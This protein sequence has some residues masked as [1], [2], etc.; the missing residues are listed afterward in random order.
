MQQTIKMQLLL[1]YSIHKC[2]YED[3]SRC[4]HKLGCHLYFR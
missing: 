4:H 3:W 2:E 1:Q